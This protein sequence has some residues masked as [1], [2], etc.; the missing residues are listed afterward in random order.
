MNVRESDPATAA[1]GASHVQKSDLGT[2]K[3][4]DDKTRW[5]AALDLGR[6]VRPASE[7]N[8]RREVNV[9]VADL[10]E[11]EL[12]TARIG[13]GCGS[14]LQCGPSLTRCQRRVRL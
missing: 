12:C 14:R 6:G 7:I 8:G 9:A 5:S 3:P 1:R 13:D 4:N 2:T 11:R 10:T